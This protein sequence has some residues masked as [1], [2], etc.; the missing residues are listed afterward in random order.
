[1]LYYNPMSAESKPEV[2]NQPTPR[3]NFV[4][5][6]WEGESGRT[7]P[8]QPTQRLEDGRRI[9]DAL[10]LAT[11]GVIPPSIEEKLTP[12]EKAAIEQMRRRENSMSWS[13]PGEIPNASGNN[14]LKAQKAYS[15][16]F[17]DLDQNGRTNE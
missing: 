17:G 10:L 9:T 5:S 14:F 4:N 8:Y 7:P 15:G 6:P 13:L 3:R 12:K 16:F 1:M 2:S 11:A